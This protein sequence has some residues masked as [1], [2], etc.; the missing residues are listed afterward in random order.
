MESYLH[1]V[2]ESLS[3][4]RIGAQLFPFFDFYQIATTDG[5]QNL[6]GSRSA[7]IRELPRAPLLVTC[8]LLNE[9][10]WCGVVIDTCAGNLAFIEPFG[11]EQRSGPAIVKRFNLWCEKWNADHEALFHTHFQLKTFPHDRQMDGNTCGIWTLVFLERLLKGQSLK[12]IDI[13]SEGGKIAKRILDASGDIDN[14]CLYCGRQ[15]TDSTEKVTCTMCLKRSFHSFCV[16]YEF[17]E[18]ACEICLPTNV[19]LHCN[20][21]GIVRLGSKEG[22]RASCTK[23]CGRFAHIECLSVSER[24]YDCLVCDRESATA[25]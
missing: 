15:I 21:C 12:K 4:N 24:P 5:A 20:R 14:M 17:S 11:G 2:M 23:G 1:V 10:H 9:N 16:H 18:F 6:I 19:P 7:S 13:V 25:V 8:V 3:R 22:N